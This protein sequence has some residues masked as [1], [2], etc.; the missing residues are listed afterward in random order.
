MGPSSHVYSWLGPLNREDKV[1]AGRRPCGLTAGE[2]CGR[3]LTRARS[4]SACRAVQ[5][6][7]ADAAMKQLQHLSNDREPNIFLQLLRRKSA[8]I[9]S[10]GP[11]QL[12]KSVQ[13]SNQ[14]NASAEVSCFDP[15]ETCRLRELKRIKGLRL[16]HIQSRSAAAVTPLKGSADRSLPLIRQLAASGVKLAGAPCKSGDC[17]SSSEQAKL[18]I[19][20]V[21]S[22]CFAL[23]KADRSRTGKDAMLR[24]TLGTTPAATS[25]IVINLCREQ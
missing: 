23:R 12:P 20:V 7:S 18:S 15:S 3:R 24:G 9:A 16:S 14:I 4:R 17:L 5:T 8:A 22:T 13:T 6:G 19:E 10:C 11:S 1:V 21:L 2:G 25:G